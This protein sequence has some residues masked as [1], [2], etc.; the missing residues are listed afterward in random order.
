VQVRVSKENDLRPAVNPLSLLWK[1]VVFCRPD[2]VWTFIK[3][4]Q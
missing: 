1:K 4:N 2:S 3:E